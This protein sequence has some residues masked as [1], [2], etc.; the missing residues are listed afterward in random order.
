M[1]NQPKV[2][3]TQAQM[4]QAAT[5]GVQLLNTPGAVN[6]PST[7]AMTGAIAVLS[8]MLTAIAN[9]EVVLMNVNPVKMPEGDGDT[10][11]AGNGEKK[12]DPKPV[13]A[14]KQAEK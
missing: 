12:P 13:D 9:R 1:E 14:G 7:M 10:P 2:D 5:A 11:P 4:Q 3:I 8:S 6:V